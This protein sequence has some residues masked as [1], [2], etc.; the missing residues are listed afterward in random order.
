MSLTVGDVVEVRR[1]EEILST[2]DDLGTLDGL[3]FMPEMLNF[4]GRRLR[5][6]KSAHKTCDTI[7]HGPQRRLDSTVHLEGTRCPGTAHGGCEAACELFWKEAWL[8]PVGKG[9][10]G[11][12]T[13]A[14]TEERLVALTRQPHQNGVPLYRCQ[15]TELLKFST[16]LSPW[17]LTQYARDVRSGNVRAWDLFKSIAWSVFRW[18]TEHLRGF[19]A[20]VWLFNKIQKLRD[21]TP[22]PLLAGDRTATPKQQLG[23]KDGDVVK[24]KTVD[25]IKATLDTAQK[26]RGLYFDVEMTPNCGA[27]FEVDR[28]VKKIIDEPTG[29]M[30][31]LPGDCI[32]LRGVVCTGRYHRHCPRAINSY[33]REVWL[34]REEQK[35]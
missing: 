1:K 20:Q 21:G 22:F 7:T 33:W 3:P 11:R 12:G 23:L 32:L 18:M 6:R 28:R 34:T 15:A 24:V 9:D 16:P 31:T 10:G 13:G 30:I 14:C 2:L 4:C 5:V 25:E 26:N 27:E 8:K 35:L 17:D 29:K 19:K